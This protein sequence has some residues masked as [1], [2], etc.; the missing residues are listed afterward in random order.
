MA[1]TAQAA[2]LGNCR[3]ATLTGLLEKNR[4]GQLRRF[5]KGRALHWQDDPVECIFAIK[6]GTVKI[7]TISP[8][9]K[10]QTYN[11]LGRDGITGAAEYLLGKFHESI[12]TALENTDVIAISPHEFD[13]L[14]AC[15]SDF[16]NMIIRELA[17]NVLSLAGKI[18]GLGFLDVQ[19]RL[20]QNLIELAEQHGIVTSEGIKIDLALTH[21]QI[22]EMVAANRATI[23]CH[24]NELLKQGYLLKSG[25]NFI[26]LPP[27][28]IEVL[29]SLNE[30]VVDGNQNQAVHWAKQVVEN[31]VDPFKAF[32]V[33]AAGMRQVDRMLCRGDLNVSD[34]ALSAYAMKSGLSVLNEHI[35]CV[36]LNA[37]ALGSVVIGTVQ[38]DIHDIGRTMV[39]MLLVAR[40]FRVIDLGID[41]STEQFLEAVQTY[42]PAILAMSS[43]MDTT[44]PEQ[45]IVVRAVKAMG[46]GGDLSIMVGGG[47]ITQEFCNEIGASG[48]AANAHDAVELALQ[49]VN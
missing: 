38:G 19:H 39:S 17:K 31:R 8:E 25:R 26:V 10:G 28:H 5:K 30:A 49:L 41:V 20:K 40:G 45:G 3:A 48:Y 42:R 4:V 9:G 47:A 22:G 16:S 46:L 13:S 43:L 15:N 34:V 44:A 36:N 14:L 21:E 33:L 35:P 12:A 27:K 6:H 37:G 24:L 29:D 18:R 11:I 23:T 2:L 7:F 32:E 1:T